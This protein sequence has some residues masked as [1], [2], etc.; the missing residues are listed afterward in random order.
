MNSCQVGVPLGGI[1]QMYD[2]LEM[3]Y[4]YSPSENDMYRSDIKVCGWSSVNRIVLQGQ[5]ATKW[6]SDFERSGR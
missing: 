6:A 1:M 2:R 5:P 4:W 3:D